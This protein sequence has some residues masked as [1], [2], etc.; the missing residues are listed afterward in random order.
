MDEVLIHHGILGQKWGIRRFQNEDGSL[1]NA[2]KKRY[3]VGDGENS[4]SS[5]SPIIIEQ[6]KTYTDRYN[7]R[8]TELRDG[9]TKIDKRNNGTLRSEDL[10][11]IKEHMQT[12][13][14][15][16]MGN[17]VS[18]I[19][20]QIKFADA[21]KM[22]G[23]DTSGSTVAVDVDLAWRQLVLAN[24]DKD[25]VK[26]YNE[27]L[28]TV[29]KFIAAYDAYNS[30]PTDMWLPIME[31]QTLQFYEDSEMAANIQKET[32]ELEEKLDKA[33]LS[34]LFEI[35]YSFSNDGKP[36]FEYVVNVPNGAGNTVPYT[37]NPDDIKGMQKF[38]IQH[39]LFS[40]D[41]RTTAS[42]KRTREKNVDTSGGAKKVTKRSK[43]DISEKERSE[44]ESNS[45]KALEE[46]ANRLSD[47]IQKVKTQKERDEMRKAYEQFIKRT[48]GYS[49][50]KTIV[51]KVKEAY[52]KMKKRL[53]HMDGGEDE[54]SDDI[55]VHYGVLGQKWGIRRYQNEDGSLTDLGKQRVNKKY[56]KGVNKLERYD[57]K[58]QKLNTKKNKMDEKLRK[59]DYKANR[60][61]IPIIESWR[62]YEKR[63]AKNQVKLQSKESKYRKLDW[64]SEKVYNKGAKWVKKMDKKF[65]NIDLSSAN[66]SQ[67]DIDYVNSYLDRILEDTRRASHQSNR[68]S[69]Y[70]SNRSSR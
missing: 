68:R 18:R 51:D 7:E 25:G 23:I 56:S 4:N 37:F 44:K 27:R 1:T 69:S 16:L 22:V 65:E 8:L 46:S 2:G 67:K 11:I 57:R 62:G 26:A 28:D 3:G 5:I 21:C 41:Y 45:K 34:G 6:R 64:K 36:I 53:S 70:L 52:E 61:K 24:I 43:V 14:G 40:K 66:V 12:M 33:G 49:E 10:V 35:S 58:V 32:N 59:F 19:Y 55:L 38:A 20:E 50:S 42:G 9:L 39:D 48:E 31:N 30:M 47:A 15:F 13:A 63:L 60:A 54:M 29:L 17:D